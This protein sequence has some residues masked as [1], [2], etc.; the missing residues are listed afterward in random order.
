MNRRVSYPAI[1]IGFLVLLMG[2]PP[3]TQ[4]QSSGIETFRQEEL[5]QM[6]AP[7]AL[8]PDSLLGQILVAATYPEQVIE[9]DVWVK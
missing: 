7:I 5:D 6:L 4:A 8:Y 1:V 9:A 3:L 2:V